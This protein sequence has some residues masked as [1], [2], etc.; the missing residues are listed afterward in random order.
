MEGRSE[1][2]VLPP[3]CGGPRE[4]NFK[5]FKKEKK[6]KAA[7]MVMAGFLSHQ[8]LFFGVS[9]EQAATN[10]E[11]QDVISQTMDSLCPPGGSAGTCG[12]QIKE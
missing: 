9:A 12:K 2:R 7:L 11:A 6:K 4:T 10:Q 5:T 8:E 3:P 1:F